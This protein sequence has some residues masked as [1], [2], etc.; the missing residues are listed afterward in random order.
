MKQKQQAC[1]NQAGQ[2]G[3][4]AQHHPV[5]RQWN[6]HKPK[7]QAERVQRILWWRKVRSGKGQE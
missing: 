6:D 5:H 4:A 3:D 1:A 7:E 2:G